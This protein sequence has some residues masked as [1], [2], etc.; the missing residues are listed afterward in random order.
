MKPLLKLNDFYQ[1][2]T[3]YDSVRK[4]RELFKNSP[5]RLFYSETE[6]VIDASSKILDIGCGI[7]FYSVQTARQLKKGRVFCLDK[8]VDKLKKLE[9]RAR[10]AG[11]DNKIA[12]VEDTFP[13]NEFQEFGFDFIYGT[14]VLHE[15]KDHA[16]FIEEVKNRL[17]PGGTVAMLDHRGGTPKGRHIARHHGEGYKVLSTKE[18]IV[19]FD[20]FKNKRVFQKKDYYLIV[21][22]KQ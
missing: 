10:K 21:A 3:V 5:N 17:K 8:R 15:F 11:V 4:L 12:I 16:G 20:D 18:V 7:G 22:E 13:T 1:K 2:S 19:L 9:V 6:K 14:Y